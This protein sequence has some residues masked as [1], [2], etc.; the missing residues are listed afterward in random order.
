MLR[1]TTRILADKPA[2]AGKHA[3]GP[4]QSST[5]KYV[6]QL[7]EGMARGGDRF[8]KNRSGTV[9][10]LTYQSNVQTDGALC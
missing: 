4:N 6:L 2:F 3:F 10:I 1:F 9:D 7:P 5:T 8:A